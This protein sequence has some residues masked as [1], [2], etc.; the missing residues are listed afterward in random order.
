MSNLPNPKPVLTV[1]RK[2]AHYGVCR[3]ACAKSEPGFVVYR[4]SQ[5]G[6]VV[7]HFFDE[8][9]AIEYAKWK[10]RKATP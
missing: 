10:N 5:V 8:A 1:D 4:G 9:D 6:E 7:A 3:R 2:D